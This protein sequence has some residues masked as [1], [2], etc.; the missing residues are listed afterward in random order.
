MTS[1]LTS[2]TP[3]LHGDET[4]DPAVHPSR[5][6][7]R[8]NSLR[9]RPNPQPL[10]TPKPSFRTKTSFYRR[11]H[12]L[13]TDSE[14]RR[15][16]C[17][18][19]RVYMYVHVCPCVTVRVQGCVHLCVR[20]SVHRSV[21]RCTCVQYRVYMYIQECVYVCAQESVCVS[22]HRNVRGRACV[23]RRVCTCVHRRVFT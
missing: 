17:A 20:V 2:H 13:R 16:L 5:P 8:Q 10:R 4:P 14:P 21:R 23:Y 19:A 7:P 6:L 18:H 1:A 9:G 15:T 3:T 22:V 11:G 12:P